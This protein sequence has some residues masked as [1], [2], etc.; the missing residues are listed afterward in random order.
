M[1]Y[2]RYARNLS[3]FSTLHQWRLELVALVFSAIVLGI[4]GFGRGL[5]QRPHSSDF[6]DFFIKEGMLPLILAAVFVY[7]ILIKSRPRRLEEYRY[8]SSLPLTFAKLADHLLLQELGRFIWL[9]AVPIL[10]LWTL[11]ALA[12]IT[13]I[14]R[15]SL[16]IILFY[17]ALY[18]GA[19]ALLFLIP[20]KRNNV[21]IKHNPILVF[22]F[23]FVFVVGTI[24]FVSMDAYVSGV[25][26]WILLATLSVSIFLFRGLLRKALSSWFKK[27]NLFRMPTMAQSHQ[28]R[29]SFPLLN[30]QGLSQPLLTKNLLKF[31]RENSRYVLFLTLVYICAGYL[32]S[33]NNARLEDFK[34]ILLTFT[35][36]YALFFSLK[37]QSYFS[38]STESTQLAYSLP[39][40][41]RDLYLSVYVP[42]ALWVL[43]ITTIFTVLAVTFRI[44]PAAGVLFWIKA[45]GLSLV[46]VTTALNFA[47]RSYPDDKKAQA[48]FLYWGLSLV[49]LI[50]LFYGI[51]YWIILAMCVVSFYRL[52]T[53]KLHHR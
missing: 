24:M 28:R 53:M 44:G 5:F 16:I 1:I 40:R 15:V 22:L 27:N 4:G 12:P 29:Q 19:T 10:I 36:I 14:C 17:G 37:S 20:S 25:G 34:S 43:A 47:F 2:K 8:L 52:W 32:A 49:V 38:G 9:P 18:S 31:A 13:F 6:I 7:I 26:F 46:F 23:L 11:T 42:A 35:V 33:R 51:R 48:S 21:L 41:R 50:A 30:F 39:V 45:A 3:L